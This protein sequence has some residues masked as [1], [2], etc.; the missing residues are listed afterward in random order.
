MEVS[1]ECPETG[2]SFLCEL[3]LEGG[4]ELGVAGMELGDDVVA[5]GLKEEEHEL[6]MSG[7]G[8]VEVGEDPV[9]AGE[10]GGGREGSDEDICFFYLCRR[11]LES[12]C[13]L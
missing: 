8:G 6:A 13:H 4:E 3:L 5:T 9:A 2:F 1:G 11:G 12:F 10:F 7:L